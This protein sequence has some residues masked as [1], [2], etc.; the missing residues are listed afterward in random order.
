MTLKKYQNVSNNLKKKAINNLV[1][2]DN[3]TAS[4]QKWK[5]NTGA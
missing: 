5:V 2:F 4:K 1:T 3:F